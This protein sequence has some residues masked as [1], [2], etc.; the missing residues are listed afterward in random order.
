MLAQFFSIVK[1]KKRD[2]IL[3]NLFYIG[4]FANC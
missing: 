3:C 1:I 4:M 2:L